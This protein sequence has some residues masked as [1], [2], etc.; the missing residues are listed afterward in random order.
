MSGWFEIFNKYISQKQFPLPFP[1]FFSSLNTME[2]HSIPEC[3]HN[4]ETV[5]W[6]GLFVQCLVCFTSSLHTSEWFQ[7]QPRAEPCKVGSPLP[8]PVSAFPDSKGAR[9]LDS[10]GSHK[11]HGWPQ[12]QSQLIPLREGIRRR[13]SYWLCWD[14]IMHSIG[15]LSLR[16]IALFFL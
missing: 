1:F 13:Q 11:L 9:A 2:W 15:S 7:L 14:S 4:L 6:R 10:P 5:F 12:P 3:Y 8:S 16:N